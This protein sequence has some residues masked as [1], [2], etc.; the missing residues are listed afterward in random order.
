M[1]IKTHLTAG[2][3][4]CSLIGALIGGIIK[5]LPDQLDLADIISAIFVVTGVFTLIS[6]IPDIV[7]AI[8]CFGTF[9]GAVDLASAILGVASGFILIFLHDEILVYAIVAYLIIFPTVRILA[10]ATKEEKK[11]R[12]KRL[13]PKI[14]TGI[15][16]IAALPAIAGLADTVFDIVLKWVGW[17][18]IALSIV[19][20]IVSLLVI[21]FHPKFSYKKQDDPNTIYVDDKDFKEKDK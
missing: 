6:S 14:F 20:L 2:A 8:I 17:G 13:F 16:L 18:I 21:H 19:F 7:Y 5:N 3:V 1:K 12:F 11:S 4:I 9:R 10:G 15:L